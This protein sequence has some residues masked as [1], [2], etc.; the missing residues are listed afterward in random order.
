MLSYVCQ[1]IF[2]L[3]VSLSIRRK[4]KLMDVTIWEHSTF[5]SQ[6]FGCGKVYYSNSIIITNVVQILIPS[7][8][9]ENV[10]HTYFG[11]EN[12]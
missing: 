8:W 2:N 6:I 5:D 1:N 7:C 4:I 10:F 11:I 9:F 12:S 3:I